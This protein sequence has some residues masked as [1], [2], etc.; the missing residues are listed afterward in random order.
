LKLEQVLE[1]FAEGLV[2]VDS[3]T[4][5][6]SANQRTG[7]IYLPGVKTLREPVFVEELINWWRSKYENDF[8][9]KSASA[10]E[11]PYPDVA[12]AKCDLVFSTDGSSLDNPEWAIE[13]KHIAH[14]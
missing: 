7:E 6:S 11:V 14:S 9:P 12:R 8:N 3:S 13:V 2:A 1:R 4:T 10:V 5:H